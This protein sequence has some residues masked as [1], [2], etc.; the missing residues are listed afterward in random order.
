MIY[1]LALIPAT[2]LVVAGYV[3]LFLAQRSEGNFQSFG[4]Y[5]GFWAICLPGLVILWAV[6]AAALGVRHDDMMRERG[7]RSM[8]RNHE[9]GGPRYW[10]HGFGEGPDSWQPGEAPGAGSSGTQTPA[11]GGPQPPVPPGSNAATPPH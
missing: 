5:L 2:I 1:F 7:E 4:K 8:M 11:T 9:P 10:G 3:A 6:F